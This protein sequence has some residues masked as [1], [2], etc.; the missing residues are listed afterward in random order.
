MSA[1]RWI[2]LW[3]DDHNYVSPRHRVVR[4]TGGATWGVR[5]GHVRPS[6]H[7][8]VARPDRASPQPDGLVQVMVDASGTLTGLHLDERARQQPVARHPHRHPRKPSRGEGLAALL[9]A[10]VACGHIHLITPPRVVDRMVRARIVRQLDRCL[11]SEGVEI[12]AS[13]WPPRCLRPGSRGHQ[14][15]VPVGV[16]AP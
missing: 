11:D 5:A 2:V 1:R 7:N 14:L 3:R 8:T 10:T 13:G 15:V 9:G 4:P 16:C 6:D 12:V